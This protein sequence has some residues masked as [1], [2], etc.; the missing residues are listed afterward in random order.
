[1]SGGVSL[2]VKTSRTVLTFSLYDRAHDVED[3]QLDTD[4]YK[5]TDNEPYIS[6]PIKIYPETRTKDVSM[7][8]DVQAGHGFVSTL[9]LLQL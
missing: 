7:A 2:F 5:H 4:Y 6:N 9:P 3:P 8:T 1:M